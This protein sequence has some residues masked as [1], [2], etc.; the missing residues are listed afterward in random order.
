MLARPDETAAILVKE[1]N[2][3]PDY[4]RRAIADA[5][6]LKLMPDGLAA[7]EPG[8]R[9][10]FDTLKRAGLVPADAA[11]RH[12][13]VCRPELSSRPPDR[14]PCGHDLMCGRTT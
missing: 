7:S 11:V 4:A 5:L 6:Q 10:V 9:R 2:T 14:Q 3:T 8:M 13:A 1:L 12:G